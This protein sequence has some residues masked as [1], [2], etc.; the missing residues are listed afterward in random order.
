MITLPPV[1]PSLIHLPSHYWFTTGHQNT[2]S[3]GSW[4][5]PNSV[6][7][8]ERKDIGCGWLASWWLSLFRMASRDQKRKTRHWGS[9]RDKSERYR[10]GAWFSFPSESYQAP[11]KID[12]ACSLSSIIHCRKD[13]LWQ[14]HC[15]Y[16]QSKVLKGKVQKTMIARWGYAESACISD[17]LQFL[18]T[19][20]VA[21][22]NEKK[23]RTQVTED[24]EKWERLNCSEFV[25]IEGVE[26]MRG[27]GNALA[28][29][30]MN[31]LRS[32]LLSVGCWLRIEKKGLRRRG[33]RNSVF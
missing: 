25:V 33:I 31:G 27:G 20:E 12:F 10:N 14:K 22:T 6:L 28:R 3:V 24:L 21:Q 4:W 2:F 23:L 32:C 29:D 30:Q 13:A 1:Y 8:F 17:Q 15:G 18:Y 9:R 11:Q 19:A 26:G 5:M 16:K 7:N